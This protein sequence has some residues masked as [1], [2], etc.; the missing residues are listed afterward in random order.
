ML[1]KEQVKTLDGL[2][3]LSV[4]AS[5]T[6]SLSPSMSV[7]VLLTVIVT[8]FGIHALVYLDKLSKC[9]QMRFAAA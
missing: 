8:Y 1:K 7:A 3:R 4:R 9:E 6:A 2:E 5:M